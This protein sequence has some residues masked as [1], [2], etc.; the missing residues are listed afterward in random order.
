MKQYINYTV[1]SKLNDKIQITFQK[2]KK[3][4]DQNSLNYE[5]QRKCLNTLL[6]AKNTEL[7]S[8]F[9]NLD[10]LHRCAWC[11]E[12]NLQIIFSF[13]VLSKHS[14]STKTSENTD[15]LLELEDF[16]YCTHDRDNYTQMNIHDQH[17]NFTK[18]VCLP[19]NQ[20][21]SRSGLNPN[22]IEF[23]AKS[24]GVQESVANQIILK[25][26]KQPFYR[27]NHVSEEDYAQYQDRF[28]GKSEEEKRALV[29]KQNHQRQ[30]DGYIQKYGDEIGTRKWRAVQDKKVLTLEKFIFMYGQEEGPKR[31]NDWIAKATGSYENFV[32]R[33]GENAYE[34]WVD[35]LRKFQSNKFGKK[36][37]THK[38]ELLRQSHERRFYDIMVEYDLHFENYKIEVN[39][40]GS[41]YR[42]DF[43]FEDINMY[44]EIAGMMEISQYNKKMNTKK[45]TFGAVICG[46]SAVEMRLLCVEI[47]KRLDD[48]RKKFNS[49]G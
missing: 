35:Y 26:N 28:L 44:I 6:K 2:N 14:K 19:K 40:P 3:H 46:T 4:F 15:Y 18:F 30:L 49:I 7:L 8:Q 10:K 45:D 39:Y 11:G 36:S 37:Y 23:V 12:Y 32:V 24:R 25:R 9:I 27:N 43:F 33:F 48:V 42:T 31:H 29:D 1:R 41:R 38:N 22:S 5:I 47:R 13:R 17:S 16:F 21:C 34:K 20:S